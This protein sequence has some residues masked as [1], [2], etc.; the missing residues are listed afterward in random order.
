MTLEWALQEGSHQLNA[1][2]GE[3]HQC[4]DFVGFGK[5]KQEVHC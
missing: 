1:M 2:D 3:I 4:R 5:L